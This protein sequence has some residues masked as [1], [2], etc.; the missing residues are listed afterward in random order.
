M[1][2]KLF[3][4]SEG[5]FEGG[6]KK[7]RITKYNDKKKKK[8]IIIG[9]I[10]TEK[11]RSCVT[12]ASVGWRRKRERKRRIKTGRRCAHL[13]RVYEAYAEQNERTV[14]FL[15]RDREDLPPAIAVS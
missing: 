12:R 6:K 8:I 2:R 3:R 1:T 15:F 5:W 14:T 4:G 9:K 13:L 11:K 10:R 7:R